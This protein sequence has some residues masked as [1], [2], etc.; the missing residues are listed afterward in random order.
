ML[1]KISGIKTI[2]E[3]TYYDAVFN[4]FFLDQKFEAQYIEER[5]FGKLFEYFT[6]LS[7]M[8]SCL[9]LFGLS[10]LIS[11][12]RQKEIGVRKVMGASAMTIAVLLSKDYIKLM[13]IA[14]FIATPATYF[15][16]DVL[17]FGSQYYKIAIGA[18][19]I[20]ISLAIMLLLGVG[21]VLSQTVK[22]A[23]ANPV[24]TLRYE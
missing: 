10:L 23:R 6:V 14:A 7:I 11:T 20:V 22:A 8:I 12:K 24:D 19:E 9:G 5:Y 17:V 4:S 21:T 13:V 2:W 1:K 3:Q 15:F 18:I 16:F